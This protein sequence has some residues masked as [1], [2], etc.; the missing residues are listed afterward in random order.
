MRGLQGKI[1]IVTGATGI[2]GVAIAR[3]LAAEGATVVATSR[4]SSKA[5]RVLQDNDL[6]SSCLAV[7]LDLLDAQS[8]RTLVEIV[9]QRAGV[10]SILVANATCR[11]NISHAFNE[12]TS[13]DF[14]SLI[15]VDVAGHCLL[16][17]EMV[18]ALSG[19]P[20]SVIFMSSVY[21]T[22]GVD[23]RIYPPGFLATPV[24]YAAAKGAA[25][26][27]VRWLA[28]YW[29]SNRIRVNSIAAGGVVSERNRR[30]EFVEKYSAKTMLG[31]MAS[32]EEIASTVAFLA[33]DEASYITGTCI[34]VDGGFSSW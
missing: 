31:R 34:A 25:I 18:R 12:F 23:H 29:G 5:E 28:A 32:A 11:E 7:E 10:P 14:S 15:G 16:A 27:T 19:S 21:G 30:D 2:L 9:C 33:S 1:A 6:Q 22:I 8:I 26:S 24:H 3:R 4:R 17:R 13:G 20:G